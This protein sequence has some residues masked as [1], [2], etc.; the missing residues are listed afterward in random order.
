MRKA[1]IL[2]PNKTKTTGSAYHKKGFSV[3]FLIK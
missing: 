1:E 3:N 2:D